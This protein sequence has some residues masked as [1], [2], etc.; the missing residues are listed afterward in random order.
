MFQKKPTVCKSCQKEIQTYQD[1]I[2]DAKGELESL[3]ATKDAAIEA[4]RKEQNIQKKRISSIW[5]VD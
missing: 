5:V 4:A 1:K 3:Q 2:E